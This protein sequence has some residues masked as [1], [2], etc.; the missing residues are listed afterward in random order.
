M[1]NALH[2]KAIQS[3]PNS[4]GSHDEAREKIRHQSNWD[5]YRDSTILF[6]FFQ[7]IIGLAVGIKDL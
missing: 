7:W 4:F 1:A 3:S 5:M 2:G 6:T